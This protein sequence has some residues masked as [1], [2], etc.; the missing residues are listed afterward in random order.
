MSGLESVAAIIGI[1]DA[2]FRSIS[3]LYESFEDLKTAPREVQSLKR[4]LGTL[5]HCLT[6]LKHLS[7]RDEKALSVIKGFGLQEVLEL[8][9]Q[10][11]EPLRAITRNWSTSVVQEWRL[12]FQ[13]VLN[14]KEIQ[15]AR[16]NVNSAKQ[17]TILA[18]VITQL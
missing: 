8:C 2:A 1:T 9:A 10:A 13:F 18:V 12:R 15:R 3:L 16:D 7:T 6:Q 5:Q 4:E 17:T 14:K 11:C